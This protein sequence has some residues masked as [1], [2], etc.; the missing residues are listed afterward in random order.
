MKHQ[1]NN[2]NEKLSKRTRTDKTF[3]INN[4]INDYEVDSLS[5]GSE[6]ADTDQ[7]HS[8]TEAL[9]AHRIYQYS[10]TKLQLQELP[11]WKVQAAIQ[12]LKTDKKILSL[13]LESEISMETSQCLKEMLECNTTLLRFQIFSSYSQDQEDTIC[14][15]IVEGIKL[16][17]SLRKIVFTNE[18]VYEFNN[19]ILK[20][21]ENKDHI[22]S[23]ELYDSGSEHKHLDCA[24]ANYIKNNKY[25][26]ELCVNYYCE[27]LEHDQ[28]IDKFFK[29]AYIVDA[30]RTNNSL[31]KLW[32]AA[33]DDSIGCSLEAPIIVTTAQTI[34]RF[35]EI[36]KSNHILSSLTKF[37]I[38][39]TANSENLDL[40]LSRNEL[41]SE[42][43]VKLV[44]N[45][46]K[47]STLKYQPSDARALFIHETTSRNLLEYKVKQKTINL[48]DHKF[49]QKY[50]KFISEY[51]RST[52]SLEVSIVD[53]VLYFDQ[54][55]DNQ[56]KSKLQKMDQYRA[57][58]FL[59]WNQICKSVTGLFDKGIWFEII[60]HLKY[61]DIIHGDTVKSKDIALSGDNSFNDYDE[62]ANNID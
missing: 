48:Q 13:D 39:H 27:E 9:V 18:G 37:R 61:S 7:A 54:D 50:A 33:S 2:D 14:M 22:V 44:N 42:N 29:F 24:L 31:N 52:K 45:L 28:L 49:V 21:I 30:L 16:N 12:A 5:D 10:T 32:I 34:S 46:Y 56:T 55:I 20:A 6:R 41:N 4:F 62:H 40:L 38:D 17:H 58:N 60:S 51:E 3:D 11:G 15:N 59:K 35:E 19:H 25:V 26:V 53:H 8:L 36:F 43:Y 57:D 23:V 1:N 47:E